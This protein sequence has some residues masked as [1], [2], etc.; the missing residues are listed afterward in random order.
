RGSMP[1]CLQALPRANATCPSRARAGSEALDGDEHGAAVHLDVVALHALAL[2]HDVA[3]GGHVVLPA[4]P[5]T[6]DDG[7]VELVFAERAAGRASRGRWARRR[8][9]APPRS[10]ASS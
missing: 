10:A 4:V 5:G 3:A 7:A 8:E 2:V 1:P 6:G 9:A